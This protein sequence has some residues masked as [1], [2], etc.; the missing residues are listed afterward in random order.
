MLHKMGKTLAVTALILVLV[1]VS[2]ITIIQS[3]DRIGPT[4]GLINPGLLNSSGVKDLD[5][6]YVDGKIYLN[7]ELSEPKTC[8]QLINTLKIQTI[9]VKT[10]TYQPT[11]I[12]ISDTLIRV[13]Y[14]QTI[15]A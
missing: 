9:I 4:R 13:T 1:L 11:C 15:S 12:K 6:Q 5:V 2:T 8:L 7:V 3:L 10:R 14:T